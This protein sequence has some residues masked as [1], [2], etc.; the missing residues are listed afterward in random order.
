MAGRDDLVK[1]EQPLVAQI[2][3]VSEEIAR[4]QDALKVRVEARAK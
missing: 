1:Q 3:Q 2:A 4:I